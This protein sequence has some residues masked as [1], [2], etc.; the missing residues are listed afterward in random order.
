M[1]FIFF[2]YITFYSM[3]Q[4]NLSCKYSKLSIT[5]RHITNREN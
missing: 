5:F 2:N 1:K 4:K 3:Y